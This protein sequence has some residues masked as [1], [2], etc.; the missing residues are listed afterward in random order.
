MSILNYGRHHAQV[1]PDIRV[2][3]STSALSIIHT[4]VVLHLRMSEKFA[5]VDFVIARKSHHHTLWKVYSCALKHAGASLH[6][7]CG[8]LCCEETNMS[9]IWLH[10]QKTFL[11]TGQFASLLN[12][13]CPVRMSTRS[14]I[15]YELRDHVHHLKRPRLSRITEVRKQT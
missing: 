11:Q 3:K 1:H 9:K 2:T 12:V 7:E 4:L 8:H 15:D 5:A 10:N 14:C 6:H 13:K